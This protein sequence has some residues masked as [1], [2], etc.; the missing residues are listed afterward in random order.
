MKGIQRRYDPRGATEMC[1]DVTFNAQS[2]H[3]RRTK[4]NLHK[5]GEAQ[6]VSIMEDGMIKNGNCSI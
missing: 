5:S 6:I 1:F 2:S 3:K 4:S